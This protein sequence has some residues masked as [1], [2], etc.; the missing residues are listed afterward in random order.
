MRRHILDFV[1]SRVE[2]ADMLRNHIMP[3][4]IS[5]PRPAL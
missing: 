2:G 1:D 4:L 3:A 5:F